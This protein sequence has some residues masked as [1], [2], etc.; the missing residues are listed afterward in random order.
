MTDANFK[1][2]Q[3]F[4]AP[5]FSADDDEDTEKGD[6]NRTLLK[7]AESPAIGVSEG[8]VISGVQ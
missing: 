7:T 2:F 1:T 8:S 5:F 6:T 3:D 4:T